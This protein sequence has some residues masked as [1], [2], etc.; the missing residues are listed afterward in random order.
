MH[1]DHGPASYLLVLIVAL[2]AFV[3]PICAW[4]A[5]LAGRSKKAEREAERRSRSVGG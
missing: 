4:I 2:L 1:T 3:P 5:Y